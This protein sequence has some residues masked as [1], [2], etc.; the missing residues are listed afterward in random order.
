M[1]ENCNFGQCRCSPCGR[2][3]RPQLAGYAYRSLD[4]RRRPLEFL[5]GATDGFRNTPKQSGYAAVSTRRSCEW[6]SLHTKARRLREQLPSA[7]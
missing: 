4:D 7:T 3:G 1:P 2:K 6:N 5:R